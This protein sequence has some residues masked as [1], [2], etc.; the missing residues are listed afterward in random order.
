M[1]LA[2][3]PA[4]LLAAHDVVGVVL[5]GGGVVTDRPRQPE[6]GVQASFLDRPATPIGTA[7]D[8]AVVHLDD[9]ALNPLVKIGTTTDAFVDELD[10]P[11]LHEKLAF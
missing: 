4:V 5:E 10:M 3:P 8:C 2:L 7:V 1:Q 6:H 9:P 11:R